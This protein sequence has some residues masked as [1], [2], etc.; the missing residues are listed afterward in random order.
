MH[1][2]CVAPVIA[3]VKQLATRVQYLH[4]DGDRLANIALYYPNSTHFLNYFSALNFTT[5]IKGIYT[6][7][8]L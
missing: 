1:R 6:K 8:F 4:F 2:Q 3:K 5:N 7:Y